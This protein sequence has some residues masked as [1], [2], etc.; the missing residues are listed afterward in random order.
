MTEVEWCFILSLVTGAMEWK[1]EL[2]WAGQFPPKSALPE[3]ERLKNH[4]VTAFRGHH[5]TAA[6]LPTG[7]R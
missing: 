5:V 1:S 6:H 7:S 2:S 4:R 3:L